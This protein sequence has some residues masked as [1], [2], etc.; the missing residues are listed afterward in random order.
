MKTIIAGGRNFH[1]DIFEQ[2][3]ERAIHECG[4]EVTEIVCGDAPGID[5]I[6]SDVGLRLGIPVVYFPADWKKYKKAAGPIRNQSMAEYADA[7]IAVWDGKSTGTGDM[8]RRAK[9]EFLT[10]H[11]VKVE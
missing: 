6:G 8:I 10:V 1:G 7:L 11:I 5:R 4:W 2:I 3:V 9:R